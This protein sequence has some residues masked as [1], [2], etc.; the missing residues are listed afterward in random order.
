MGNL[1]TN[2]INYTKLANDKYILMSNNN[3]YSNSQLGMYIKN[4][5]SNTL[6]TITPFSENSL[7]EMSDLDLK[8]MIIEILDSD[9]EH[10]AYNLLRNIT[11][12]HLLLRISSL[13]FDDDVDII[14]RIFQTG[15]NYDNLVIRL[16]P[17]LIDTLK[18]Q[19]LTT[20]IV[21][22]LIVIMIE[23]EYDFSKNEQ[24]LNDNKMV[25]ICFEA[26]I[27]LFRLDTFVLILECTNNVTVII[28]NQYIC[29]LI[30]SYFE[31]NL[32]EELKFV[33]QYALARS[34]IKDKSW[35]W[36]SINYLSYNFTSCEFVRTLP[37][38]YHEI[39]DPFC[40]CILNKKY[41]WAVYLLDNY[42]QDINNCKSCDLIPLCIDQI[43]YSNQEQLVNKIVWNIKFSSDE[44]MKIIILQ[45][46]ILSKK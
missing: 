40:Y 9:E 12:Q 42:P 33:S 18:N 30:I 23:K 19:L 46:L 11:N 29:D 13:K 36:Y 41:E 34:N 27:Y 26:C 25:Y 22:E 31:L 21:Y 14:T 6:N 37:Y 45:N 44:L 16:S 39:I 32:I 15:N 24:I 17:L 2:L 28:N 20:N 3:I 5:F 38:P 43:L 35:L 7:L 10:I 8:N 4:N 1:N